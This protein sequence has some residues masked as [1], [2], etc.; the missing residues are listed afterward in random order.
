LTLPLRGAAPSPSRP[1]AR[2]TIFPLAAKSAALNDTKMSV[3]ELSARRAG[4]TDL[5]GLLSG[6]GVCKESQIQIAGPDGLGA[7]LWLCRHG[8]EHVAYVK[9]GAPCPGEPVEVLIAP[10][11]MTGD[12]LARLLARA[13]KLPAGGVLVVQV[14]GDSRDASAL[15]EQSGYEIADRIRRGDRE[16]ITARKGP[17]L[18][19]A[20]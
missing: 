6:L 12:E 11:A 10:H 7:L 5:A 16:L 15:L 20:A 2:R 19:H 3:T 9:G 4:A 8:Y 14:L 18:A 13:A 1:Y 17:A